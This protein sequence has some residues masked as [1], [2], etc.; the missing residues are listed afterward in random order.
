MAF[1]LPA[2]TVF[3]P[4]QRSAEA[5]VENGTLKTAQTH[6]RAFDLSEIPFWFEHFDLS[7]F[8]IQRPLQEAVVRAVSHHWTPAL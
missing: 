6:T 8:H 2:G 1:W 5:K 7:C 3:V 4:H